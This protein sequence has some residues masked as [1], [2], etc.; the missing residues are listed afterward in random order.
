M[1]L[2]AGTVMAWTTTTAIPRP[3]AVSTFLEI[4]MKRAHAEEEGE[5]CSR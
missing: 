1:R 2:L 4:A 3:I 5:P